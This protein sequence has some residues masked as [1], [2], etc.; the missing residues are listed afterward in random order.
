MLPSNATFGVGILVFVC[1]AMLIRHSARHPGKAEEMLRKEYE[2]HPDE[3]QPQVQLSEEFGIGIWW[4][5][6][7]RND[8]CGDA[9]Q[10]QSIC[11][12]P[13][14][15]KGHDTSPSR[16]PALKMA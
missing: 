7:Q 15:I 13:K 4:S 14:R 9:E 1:V 5:V 3:G 2:V 6:S 10:Q 16:P 12:Y 8:R 11:R